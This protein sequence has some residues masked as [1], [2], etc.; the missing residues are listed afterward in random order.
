[1]G[2]MLRGCVGLVESRFLSRTTHELRHLLYVMGLSWLDE[3]M[4]PH[5]MVACRA[6]AHELVACR[7]LGENLFWRSYG[8]N[9]LCT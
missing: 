4:I 3:M 8:S 5:V 9:F 1:M 2:T 7:A 6:V